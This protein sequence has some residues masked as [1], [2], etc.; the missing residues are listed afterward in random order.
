MDLDPRVEKQWAGGTKTNLWVRTPFDRVG[1]FHTK[2]WGL[3]G[4]VCP[5]NILLGGMF[6]RNCRDIPEIPC[7]QK[8]RSEKW[9]NE[10]S[11]NFSNFCPQICLRNFRASFPRKRRPEK[12]HQKSPPFFNAKFP[13]KYEK[14]FTKCFWRAGK[15]TKGQRTEFCYFSLSISCWLLCLELQGSQ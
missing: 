1:V 7:A 10:S 2:G 6:Q 4:L 15:V 13:G 12:I 3:E 14:I 11:P 5:S 9:Q 8:V